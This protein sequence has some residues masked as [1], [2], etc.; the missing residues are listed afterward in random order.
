[1]EEEYCKQKAIEN[2]IKRESDAVGEKSDSVVRWGQ[3]V[4][5]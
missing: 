1:M 2:E 3:L 5:Y 4:Y